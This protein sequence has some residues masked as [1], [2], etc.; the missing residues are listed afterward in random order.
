MHQQVSK[1]TLKRRNLPAQEGPVR[2]TGGGAGPHVFFHMTAE[3]P[4][5]G[6]KPKASVSDAGHS[7]VP[8][9]G[10]EFGTYLTPRTR[11]SPDELR[12]TKL[13]NF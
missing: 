8:A 12:K 3:A 5:V 2:H 1:P 4:Q 7:F 13:L 10:T 6:G 9:G 11:L